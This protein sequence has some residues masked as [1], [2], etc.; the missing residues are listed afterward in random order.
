MSHFPN[1]NSAQN[2]TRRE[3]IR[4][5][6]AGFGMIALADLL[7]ADGFLSP[8]ARAAEIVA[9]GGPLSPKPPH[10][11]ARAK[12]IIWLFM[13]GGPSQVDTFDYKPELE[14]RD[15]VK[16]ANFDSTTGFFKLNLNSSGSSVCVK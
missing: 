3:A 9:S 4:R 7:R 16:L 2:M 11:P 1:L 10:F 5:A 15:G 12:S 13:N 8:S 6:G 14:R